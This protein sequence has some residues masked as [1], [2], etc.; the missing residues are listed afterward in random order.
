MIHAH[1]NTLTEHLNLYH[2]ILYNIISCYIY[3]YLYSIQ[4]DLYSD[5]IL[6]DLITEAWGAKYVGIR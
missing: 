5:L 4:S 3:L 2:W 6:S 1:S